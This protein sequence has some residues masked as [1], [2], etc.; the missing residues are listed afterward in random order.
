[1]PFGFKGFRS[2]KTLNQIHL[3][4]LRFFAKALKVVELKWLQPLDHMLL[5]MLY[6]R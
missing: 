1:M 2:L 5:Y 3:V 6:G 4:D